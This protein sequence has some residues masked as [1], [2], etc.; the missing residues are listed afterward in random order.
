[1]M[2]P[3][4]ASQVTIDRD[5][6]SKLAR[7]DDEPPLDDEERRRVERAAEVRLAGRDLDRGTQGQERLDPTGLRGRNQV[8]QAA[9][10][11]VG[12]VL[13]DVIGVTTLA[14]LTRCPLPA[15][16]FVLEATTHNAEGGHTMLCMTTYD[17][18]YVDDCRSKIASQVS[19]Y[20][21]LASTAR[22][23][24]ADGTTALEAFEPVFFNNL[25][26]A[27]DNYFVHRSRT[28]ELKDGNPLNEVRVLC[29]SMTSNDG[30]V[31]ADSRSS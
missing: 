29:N 27:L 11:R 28:L 16:P 17:R 24:G 2:R 18:S 3:G 1:M 8:E 4:P 21:A 31:A 13:H 9:Q 7:S 15:P 12:T 19:A 20:R 25:V 30:I 22:G 5:D 6:C 26:L 14:L 10:D 23:S